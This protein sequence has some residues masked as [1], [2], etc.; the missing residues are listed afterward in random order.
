M[1]ICLAMPAYSAQTTPQ[2]PKAPQSKG[3]FETKARAA[4]AETLLAGSNRIHL[5]GVDMIDTGSAK[6]GLRAR[7]DLDDLIGNQ[8]IQCEMMSRAGKDIIAQCA[9]INGVDLSLFMIQNGFLVVD[10]SLVYNTIFEEPYIGAEDQAK[11]K[12]LGLWSS[13]D[14]GG[15]SSSLDSTGVLILLSL[16][17]LVS[18]GSFAALSVIMLGGFNR[19][20]EAQ[21]RNTSFLNKERA[22]KDKEKTIVVAM[23]EAELKA[24]ES[25]LEAYLVIYEEML[26]SLQHSD[27]SPKYKTSGDIVQLQP[28][29]ERAIFDGNTDKLDLLGEDLSS[30]VIH[31]YA[32]VK[33]RPDYV[34]LEPDTPLEK[35]LWHVEKAVNG[36]KTMNSELEKLLKAFAKKSPQQPREEEEPKEEGLS[37]V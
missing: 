28:A 12:G 36:A 22:L 35:A 33:T 21:E 27:Q 37:F 31:F 7:A 15:S 10:R 1:L 23:L 30:A 11:D 18:G 24:N 4:D 34:N 19:V 25:K 20:V 16:L 2:Q 32:Q 29:L 9:S 3:L 13:D 6:F 14:N 26:R 5:W 17:L 8:S